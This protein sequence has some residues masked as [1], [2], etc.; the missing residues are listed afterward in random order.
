MVNFSKYCLATCKVC[1]IVDA[2]QVIRD[3]LK[4]P[5]SS[6]ERERKHFRNVAI[7]EVYLEATPT[8]FLY[9]MLFAYIFITT[10]SQNLE[11]S[12]VLFGTNAVLYSFSFTTSLI[13]AAFGI[14]R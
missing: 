13:S 5:E 1:L 12:Q 11:V 8:V 7:S 14:A 10:K 2:V 3:V 6:S 4:N 9:I